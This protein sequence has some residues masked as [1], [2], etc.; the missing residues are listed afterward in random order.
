M[1]LRVASSCSSIE[2]ISGGER[3]HGVGEVHAGGRGL[4]PQVTLAEVAAQLA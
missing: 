1:D 3:E 2:E 4:A